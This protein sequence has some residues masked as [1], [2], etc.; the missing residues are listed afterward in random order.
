VT[1]SIIS[2]F[3]S[4]RHNALPPNVSYYLLIREWKPQP[5]KQATVKSINRKVRSSEVSNLPHLSPRE[6]HLLC[7]RLADSLLEMIKTAL[8]ASLEKTKEALSNEAAQSA[9]GLMCLE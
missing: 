3:K 7:V 1:E 4:T 2:I 9:W 6:V 5:D 8:L